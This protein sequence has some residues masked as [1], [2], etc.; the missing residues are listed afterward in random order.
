MKGVGKMPLLLGLTPSELGV[1]GT[2]GPA[3][4][5]QVDHL[6][7][8]ARFHKKHLFKFTVSSDQKDKI[9]TT[10]T[11]IVYDNLKTEILCNFSV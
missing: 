5:S 9:A 10:H 7:S 3:G 1:T 11:I 2:S 6:S 8:R 4:L